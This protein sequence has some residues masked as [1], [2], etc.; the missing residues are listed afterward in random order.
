MYPCPSGVPSKNCCRSAAHITSIQVL[1]VLLDRKEHTHSRAIRANDSDASCSNSKGMM[2]EVTLSKCHT[3]TAE[4][5]PRD[6][7]VTFP[8]HLVTTSHSS[9]HC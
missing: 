8:V 7:P 1:T 4:V 5:S 3:L 6:V 2:P 9:I